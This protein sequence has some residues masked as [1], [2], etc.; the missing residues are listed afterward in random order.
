[1][2]QLPPHPFARGE[3]K[4][5]RLAVPYPAVSDCAA[6]QARDVYR[7]GDRA[8]IGR[9]DPAQR[10]RREAPCPRAGFAFPI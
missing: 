4:E 3:L 6:D 2:S 5:N 7:A 10:D 8:I 9:F 1:M